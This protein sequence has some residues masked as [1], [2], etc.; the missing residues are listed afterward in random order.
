[1]GKCIDFLAVISV[2]LG[3]WVG[4][5]DVTLSKELSV[6]DGQYVHCPSSPVDYFRFLQSNF[7][8]LPLSFGEMLFKPLQTFQ[9]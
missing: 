5:G 7:F 4:S 6:L 1:M 9:R 8:N 3:F 2:C